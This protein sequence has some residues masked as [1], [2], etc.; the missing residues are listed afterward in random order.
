M[1]VA[2]AVCSLLLFLIGLACVTSCVGADA[3]YIT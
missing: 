3:E 1:G 2:I